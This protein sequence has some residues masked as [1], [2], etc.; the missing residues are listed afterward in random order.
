MK[1]HDIPLDPVARWP[2][3]QAFAANFI[4]IFERDDEWQELERSWS[5]LFNTYPDNKVTFELWANDSD[6]R[7]FITFHDCKVYLGT[8]VRSYRG[9]QLSEPNR[10]KPAIPS[11][12]NVGAWRLGD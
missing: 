11:G 7:V 8:D 6:R 3:E 5:K 2:Y 4:M 1:I 10:I 12:I 9:G